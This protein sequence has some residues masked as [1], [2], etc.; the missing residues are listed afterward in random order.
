VGVARARHAGRAAESAARRVATKGQPWT[1]RAARAGY[2]ARGIVYVLVGGLALAAA[3]GA[4]GRP[5]DPN[6]A[7]RTLAR[8]PAGQ[9]GLGL[10]AAGLMV[11]AAF[12]ALLM[13]VGE[14]YV[15]QGRWGRVAT[16]VRH[17]FA[18]CL[19]AGMALTAAALAAGWYGHAGKDNDAETRHLSARLLAQ[20]FGRPALVAI[21]IGV[22]IAAAVQ[23]VRA[24]GPNRTR[25]RLRVQEMTARQSNFMVALGRVAHVGR[26]AVLAVC[27]YFL[28]RGAIDRAPREARGPG[29]ALRAVWELPHGG[30]W[31]ALVA[32]GLIAFGVYGVLEARWRRLVGDLHQPQR[33]RC[34]LRACRTCA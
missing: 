11:H 27:A 23:I 15:K 4:G 12:R 9:I 22:G 13:V 26:A 30:V 10:I 33:R 18:A 2:V 16:H 19:Y 1:N 3:A 8:M 21:A 25:E 24:F 34:T 31:L 5:T 20:P 17:G 14:P 7:L 6:G 32:A 29:G 28:M